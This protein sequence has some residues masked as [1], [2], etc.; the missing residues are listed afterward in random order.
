MLQC[1]FVSTY[2]AALVGLTVS[3]LSSSHFCHFVS[4]LLSTYLACL[5]SVSMLVLLSVCLCVSVSVSLLV[6]SASCSSW[7]ARLVLCHSSGLV[8]VV[9]LGVSVCLVSLCVG[10]MSYVSLSVVLSCV[11]H[12]S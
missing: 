4:V 2:L 5:I 10:C 9:R 6:A 8:T 7:Y 12:V 11:C 3:L 1:P